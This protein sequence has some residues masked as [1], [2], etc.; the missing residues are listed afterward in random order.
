MDWPTWWPSA[1]DAEEPDGVRVLELP[2]DGRH[3]TDQVSRRGD[4]GPLPS[5]PHARH[6]APSQRA[7][8]VPYQGQHV[9]PRA[10]VRRRAG[11]L[12]EVS[13]GVLAGGLTLSFGAALCVF[14]MVTADWEDTGPWGLVQALPVTYFAGL[15]LICVAAG[16]A[17]AAEGLIAHRLA[18]TCAVVLAV[19]LH[20]AP[21]LIE[22]LPRF[23]TAWLHAG[24]SDFVAATGRTAPNVDARFSW[25]AFFALSAALQDALH[26][27]SARELLSAWPVVMN[28]LYLPAVHE[29]ALRVTGSRRAAVISMLA[30]PSL[31]WVGQDY[32][33]PQSVALL[34]L[35][36]IVLI[37]IAF[38]P[39][40]DPA[41]TSD[42]GSAR[43]SGP[44]MVPFVLLLVLC[45]ALTVEHQLT[46]IAVFLMLAALVVL[47][48]TTLVLLPVW[49]GVS[50][51]AWV[52][53]G[54]TAYWSG[55]L[56][57]IFG[58][59]GEV[60][61]NVSR[62]GSERLGGSP[63]HVFVVNTRLLFSVGVWL[64]ATAGLAV[65]RGWGRWTCAALFLAPFGVLAGQSYGGEG[66]IRVYLYALP[67]VCA[68]VGAL[69]ARL[70]QSWISG[71]VVC[72]FLVLT[73]PLFLLS[74]WGN[75]S[76]EQTR[77]TE[78]AALEELY[79]I[80]PSGSTLASVR[81]QVSWRYEGAVVHKYR[82]GMLDEF[83]DVDLQGVRESLGQ[84]PRGTYVIITTGQ[85]VYGE[86]VRGLP[87]GWTLPTEEAMQATGEFQLVY[88]NP[89]A[90]IYSYR[91]RVIEP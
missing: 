17:L 64:A 10:G 60:T 35:L 87:P 75:E 48:R 57:D 24:F 39:A 89:D 25:P 88:Q 83:A 27:S 8:A 55:H 90:R 18:A 7:S 81:P 72:G 91:A 14:G 5:V 73:M 49:L 42:L 2:Q 68:A 71:A 34:L 38:F 52:S 67:A 59:L 54:A 29:L 47:R 36:G 28:L 85:L 32:Y 86:E 43:R 80:A 6:R 4:P 20:A 37:V 70:Q 13:A 31:N 40:R 58:G 56:D 78:Y 69:L 46:P 12:P 9:R 77:P 51:L 21:S 74:R 76:F 61:G 19:V 30:F 41:P 1:A 26:V 84:N 3:V 23:A 50:L 62:G 22:P 82:T 45:L 44:R 16:V 15:V 11:R 79:A 66:T 65:L 63:E 53:F 33:S